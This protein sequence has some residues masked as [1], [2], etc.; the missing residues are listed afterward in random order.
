MSRSR[1]GSGGLKGLIGMGRKKS[2]GFADPGSSHRY[3]NDRAPDYTVTDAYD[4]EDSGSGA[5]FRPPPVAAKEALDTSDVGSIGKAL[6]MHDFISNEAGDL[7]F[8]KGDIVVILENDGE[9]WTGR[10][11]TKEGI[12]SDSLHLSSVS[13]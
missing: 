5:T 1:S 3:D 9:W 12:V 4:M 7:T 2:T 11:G 8:S 6:A 10:R 13:R